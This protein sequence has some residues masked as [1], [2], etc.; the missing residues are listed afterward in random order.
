[1]SRISPG[2]WRRTRKTS[3]SAFI[4]QCPPG[5]GFY[6]TGWRG[7]YLLSAEPQVLDLLYQTGLGSRNAQGF[8]LFDLC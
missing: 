7:S 4:R 3:G 5:A 2:C 8:G 1:M 6:V